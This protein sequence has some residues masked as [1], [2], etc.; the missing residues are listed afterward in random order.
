ML[1]VPLYIRIYIALCKAPV[2]DCR[3]LGFSSSETER[4][5]PQCIGRTMLGFGLWLILCLYQA[6]LSARCGTARHGTVKPRCSGVYTWFSETVTGLS[7]SSVT[8]D[9]TISVNRKA[10]P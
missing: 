7:S 10:Q 3:E 4:S 9:L 5:L 2:A 8:F 6:R 1:C